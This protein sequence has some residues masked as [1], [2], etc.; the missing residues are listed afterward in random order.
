MTAQQEALLSINKAQK[1]QGML[2]GGLAI[3]YVLLQV[4]PFAEMELF[5]AY[6]F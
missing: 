1:V 4:L 6:L 3:S 5:S 2:L